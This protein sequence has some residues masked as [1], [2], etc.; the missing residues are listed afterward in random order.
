LTTRP[1]TID[2]RY[3]LLE[4]VGEGASGEV[5]RARDTLLDTVIAIKVLKPGYMA[6]Q[7]AL[8]RVRQEIVLSR[9]IGHPNILRTYHLGEYAGRPYITMQWVEGATLARLIADQGSLSLPA[10]IAMAGKLASALAAAHQRKILHRDIKPGNILVDRQGEPFLADFGLA[11]LMGGPGITSHQYFLGTPYYA[12]PE[13]AE[14]QPLD[15][16]SDLYALGMVLFE[17]VT[18]RRPFEAETGR[19]VLKMQRSTPP[20]DP[21]QLA[22]GLPEGLASLILRCLEK[23]PVRRYA[24]AEALAA[25]IRELPG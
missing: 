15:E 16:R 6:N 19:E 14:L 3:S 12:S 11:R 17:M 23:D 10:C 7:E 18:G 2:S 5:Y 21:R 4:K 13:Q 1:E 20:P 25:A 24:S 8:E 22:P 9:D